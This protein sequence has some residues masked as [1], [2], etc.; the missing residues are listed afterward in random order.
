MQYYFAKATDLQNS[1]CVQATGPIR[2]ILFPKR[3]WRT[4]GHGKG[5]SEFSGARSELGEAA[6]PTEVY[7]SVQGWGDL[8]RVDEQHRT[9]RSSFSVGQSVTPLH[10]NGLI[11]RTTAVVS[12]FPGDQGCACVSWGHLTSSSISPF[13]AVCLQCLPATG[14][15]F[16]ALHNRG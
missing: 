11:M 1:T 12:L 6:R 7:S 14:C 9:A 4:Y 2:L 5:Q 16:S 15:I 8:R 3:K 13:S 10:R